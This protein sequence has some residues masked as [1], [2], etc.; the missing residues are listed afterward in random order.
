MLC[1]GFVFKCL[2]VNDL[3]YGLQLVIQLVNKVLLKGKKL[4][5]E[6]IVYGVFE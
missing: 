3:V 1:K 2:L 4:L 6:C 5:V